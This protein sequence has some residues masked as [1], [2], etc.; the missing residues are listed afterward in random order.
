MPT[1]ISPDDLHLR[2][3]EDAPIALIDVR[4]PPEYNA[5]HI[6]GSSL[7]PRR[8][9][10]FELPEAV[11]HRDTPIVLCDEDE[12]RVH[13]AAATAER[14]GYSGCFGAGRA[15]RIGGRFLICRPSGA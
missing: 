3:A 15:G 4:D 12:G 8:M 13:F 1:P 11:P 2:L 9:L 6:V 7:I 5:S 14:M 10:E